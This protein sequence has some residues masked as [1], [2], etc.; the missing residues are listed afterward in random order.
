MRHCVEFCRSTGLVNSAERMCFRHEI[1]PPDSEAGPR[2]P[3]PPVL[4]C[5]LK[6]A[7]ARG[8]VP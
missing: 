1:S 6:E 3:E 7:T 4:I 5:Q 8:M 2:I